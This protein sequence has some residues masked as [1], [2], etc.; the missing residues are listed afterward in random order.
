MHALLEI[1]AMNSTRPI[2]QDGN[3]TRRASICASR[4]GFV[5]HSAVLRST[6]YCGPEWSEDIEPLRK[7]EQSLPVMFDTWVDAVVSNLRERAAW[8]TA[9]Q[10]Q[11]GGRVTPAGPGVGHN[12][13]TWSAPERLAPYLE[14][15]TPWQL[16]ERLL[17]AGPQAGHVGGGDK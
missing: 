13:W 15:R 1:I 17:V 9:I 16:V 10:K 14:T 2:F 4:G 5:L 8:R 6:T 3:F 7:W 12:G 11:F